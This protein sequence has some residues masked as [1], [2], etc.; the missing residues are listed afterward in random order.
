MLEVLPVLIEKRVKQEQPSAPSVLLTQPQIAANGKPEGYFADNQWHALLFDY[1][2]KIDHFGS[3]P[4]MKTKPQDGSRAV[5]AKSSA[6]KMDLRCD[7]EIQEQPRAPPNRHYL[8][9]FGR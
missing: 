1:S 2:G 6:D 8:C 9:R 3:Y 7:R 5:F 4:I